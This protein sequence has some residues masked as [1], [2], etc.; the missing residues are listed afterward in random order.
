MLI[1]VPR[2][3]AR[4][5]RRVALVPDVV[6][7]LTRAGNRIV[8]ERGA[9]QRAGFTDEA[10]RAAGCDLAD[11]PAEIYSS[12]QMILKV[13]R[14]AREEASGEAELDLLRQGT[15]LIGL[16]QPS[17]D[18]A[19]F[20]QLAERKIIACSMELVPRTSRAQMMD[21][22]SS[23]STVA[24]Y[25]AVLIAAN[26]LQK[27]F[28]MLM[29]A[30]GTVRPARVLVIGAGV[31]GL[32]AIATARRIG[33]VVEAFDTRPVVKEQVQSLGA[34]FVELDVHAE[35]AQDAGGYA[36]ELSREH[37]KREKE[38]IHKRALEA[39][40]IITT[41]LIPGKPAP[42]LI[43]ADTVNAMRP[44]SVIVD[45]AGEQGGNCELSVPGETIV[46]HDVTIIA[47]LHISSDLAYHASQ[48]YAK[49]VAALVALLAPKGELNLNFADDI[50]SAVVITAGGEIRHAPTRQRLG[51][52]NPNLSAPEPAK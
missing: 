4:G 22:L 44:G 21:A 23:Q 41:A 39:D 33:A 16:L 48:M 14:P 31:A 46:Q 50:I 12:A 8:V 6:P 17:G 34:T 10:Y 52:S 49:N 40:V 9:G 24:G 38:L 18:P 25:K 3:V 32:Q 43:D 5:E 30:A 27:F 13:Q 35:Q 26:A 1:G 20:Q 15:T 29:T 47:P 28:P 51:M 45:L 2:E 11:V 7:Q 42:M 37:I 19:L 36:K